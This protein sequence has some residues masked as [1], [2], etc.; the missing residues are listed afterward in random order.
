MADL[1]VHKCETC[2]RSSAI[3]TKSKIFL[4][5][6][7]CLTIKHVK[8]FCP[9]LTIMVCA[10]WCNLS[11]QISS[12]RIT[13][14]MVHVYWSDQRMNLQLYE[15]I[16]VSEEVPGQGLYA[17]VCQRPARQQQHQDNVTNGIQLAFTQY[18]W[19]CMSSSWLQWRIDDLSSKKPLGK[20]FP[21]Q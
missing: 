18:V 11:K 17:V 7:I 9:T 15:W 13:S 6:D 4:W 21:V 14:W 8:G 2:P 5:K 16:H 12:W 1:Q 10:P 3:L 19:Y 20:S